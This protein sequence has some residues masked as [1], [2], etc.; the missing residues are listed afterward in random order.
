MLPLFNSLIVAVTFHHDYILSNTK[1]IYINGLGTV[2]LYL[3]TNCC[4]RDYCLISIYQCSV[5]SLTW[6][7]KLTIRVLY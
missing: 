5:I 7:N 6:L 1:V 3:P 2:A 4:G